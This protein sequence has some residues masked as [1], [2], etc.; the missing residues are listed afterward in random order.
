MYHNGDFTQYNL[1]S[2]LNIFNLKDKFSLYTD[3]GIGI[4]NSTSTRSFISDD[5]VFLENEVESIKTDIGFGVRYNYNDIIS[6]NIDRS[7]NRVADDG[8]D[9]W[10][11]GTGNDKFV[12]TSIG[13]SYRLSKKKVS[14][15]SLITRTN[16]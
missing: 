6:F 12:F 7:F 8:F 9:G 3:A 5:V 2:R 14:V 1:S 10:D 11:D 16:W 15:D 13:I 4:I